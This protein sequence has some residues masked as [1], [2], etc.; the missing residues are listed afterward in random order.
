MPR[1]G[2]RPA[3]LWSLHPTFHEDVAR[4]VDEEG[5]RLSFFDIDDAENNIKERNT[6]ITYGSIPMQE[7]PVPFQR[8]VGQENRYTGISSALQEMQCYWLTGL[9]F[10]LCRN[11][12]ILD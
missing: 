9:G 3:A 1:G 11:S 8:L 10:I 2:Q 5:L 7:S 6:N 4:L 12:F